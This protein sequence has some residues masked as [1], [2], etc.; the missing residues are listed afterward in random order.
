[1]VLTDVESEGNSSRK[2]KGTHELDKDDELHTE[3][4]CSAEI[5]DQDQFHEVVDS[6]VDP[7]S[8]LGEK[9]LE[10]VGYGGLANSLW[11]EHL[12]PL[13]KSPQHQGREITIFSKEKQVFLVQCVDNVFGIMLHNV[14]VSQDWHPVILVAFWCLDSVHAETSRKTGNTT[15]NRFE[16]FGHMM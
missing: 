1:M 15:E 16:G 14:G 8:S 12:L 7:S 10:F 5:T 2:H 11:H 3:A 13:G 4:E 6:T 9:D